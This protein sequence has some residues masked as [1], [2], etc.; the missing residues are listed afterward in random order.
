M[1][2]LRGLWA[3]KR[4][5]VV[6]LS[7]FII[8]HREELAG[9]GRGRSSQSPSPTS[10]GQLPNADPVLLDRIAEAL[11]Q[12]PAC[13]M[14]AMERSAT[15]HGGALSRRGYSVGQVVREFRDVYQAVSG[16]AGEIGES[17]SADEWNLLELCLDN[18]AAS[19][20]TEYVRLR[21]EAFAKGETER[22]GVLAHELRNKIAAASLGFQAIKSGRV[23]LGGSLAT[24]V[25]RSL[26]GM[27]GLIDR[28]L[29]EVR[30][31]T[32]TSRRQRVHLQELL[33]E[34]EID[35]A[36]AAADRGVFLAVN[37]LEREVDVDVDP[38]ML[39]G[40]IVNLLQ[41]AFKFTHAGGRVV[42]RATVVDARVEIA[43]E[44]ECGGL[45]PGKAAELFGAFQ[46]CGA[47]RSGLGLGLHVSR[48]AVEAS[49][50]VIRVR[51]RPGIGCVFTIDLP[52]VSIGS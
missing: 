9:M 47:D 26:R 20:A 13:I 51:D 25:A 41:N 3:R 29:N 38:L 14:G 48:R 32:G 24:V 36:I 46:Q 19:A 30:L 21:D 49:G 12:H 33:G 7:E 43:V 5:I 18:G 34:T 2:P 45:P 39:A 4:E 11:Q 10:T 37:P 35:A 15:L 23:P 22:S 52:R 27:T 17:I 1:H 6:S 31:N 44:D 40:A 28:E 50:G 8:A 16:L 42:L